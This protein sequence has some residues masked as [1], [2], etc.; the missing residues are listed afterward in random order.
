MYNKLDKFN[1][2]THVQPRFGNAHKPVIGNAWL[3]TIYSVSVPESLEE[4]QNSWNTLKT[5]RWFQTTVYWQAIEP[6][7][8]GRAFAKYSEAAELAK[9]S[10]NKS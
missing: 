9:Y 2:F 10:K 6:G 4:V 7:R 1:T 8:Q 3:S 5:N